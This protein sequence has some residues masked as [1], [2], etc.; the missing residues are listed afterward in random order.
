MTWLETIAD[1]YRAQGVDA[2]VHHGDVDG[3]LDRVGRGLVGGAGNRPA[4]NDE[5][6]RSG[7]RPSGFVCQLRPRR[8]SAVVR[9][10]TMARCAAWRV[11]LPEQTAVCSLVSTGSFLLLM[12]PP[13]LWPGSAGSTQRLRASFGSPPS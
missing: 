7:R 4:V 1:I 11:T 13:G 10:V 12:P 5:L 8:L 2:R 6:G 3:V 9:S